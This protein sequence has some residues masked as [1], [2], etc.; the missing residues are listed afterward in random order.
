MLHTT[1]L[2]SIDIFEKNFELKSTKF[3]VIT[4]S[5]SIRLN[6]NKQLEN[7]K[8]L[9]AKISEK[10]INL[11]FAYISIFAGT[12]RE[13]ILDFFFEILTDHGKVSLKNAER[14]SEEKTFRRV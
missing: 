5:L 14:T 4:S 13:N 1:Q 6:S 2:V 9:A 11:N 8:F 12:I 10:L 7:N 3:P